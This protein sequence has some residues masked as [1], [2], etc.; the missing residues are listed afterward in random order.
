MDWTL[1]LVAAAVLGWSLVARRLATTVVSAALAFTALGVVAGPDGLGWLHLGGGGLHTTT[2]GALT[3]VLFSDAARIDVPA[4]RRESGVPGRLLGIGLPLTILAG[5]GVALGLFDRVGVWAAALLAT[6]LAPTDA[7]LSQPTVTDPRLPSRVRQ[8]LNV[9]SGL[10]D[11]LC[12]PL[13]AI[14]LVLAEAEEGLTGASALRLVADAI[15][16][17]VLAGGVVGAAGAGLLGAARGRG[18]VEGWSGPIAVLALPALAYGLA[19]TAGGSGFIA[20]FAAG[21]AFGRL[22]GRG[23]D[24]AEDLEVTEAVG[25]VLTWVTFLVFGAVALGPALDQLTARAVLYA[26]LSLTVIRLVP[27]ALAFVGSGARTPTVAFLGWF[28]PRGLASIVFTLDLIDESGLAT[29]DELVLAV[30]ATVGLS[31]FLHGLTGAPGTA[32]YARWFAARPRAGELMESRPVTVHRTRGERPG[33]S[34]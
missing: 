27:V 5:T 15:G 30:V 12:V 20:A 4:L 6:T 22:R 33:P 18:W 19:D 10:N 34:R 32:A 13:V 2:I 24:S 31:V 25:S 21:V 8:G 16:Y 29:T 26:V 9:E 1:A 3:L 28:G 14:F 23:P 7:A 11:G 17:G